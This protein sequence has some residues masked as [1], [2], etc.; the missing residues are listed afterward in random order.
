MN[1]ATALNF[2]RY[3]QWLRI[4]HLNPS[5]WRYLSCDEALY[6][7]SPGTQLVVIDGFPPSISIRYIRNTFNIRLESTD[8]LLEVESLR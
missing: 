5:E 8:P 1:Y 4:Q 6:G 2:T 7:F 3:R